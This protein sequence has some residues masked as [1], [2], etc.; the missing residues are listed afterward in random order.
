MKRKVLQLFYSI[1]LLLTTNS[2][3]AQITDLSITQSINNSVPMVGTN[4]VFTI[5]ASNFGPN[6]A[7]VVVVSDVLPTGYAFV[8]A[9]VSSGTTSSGVIWSIGNLASGVTETMTLVATVLP[10]GSYNNCASITGME[11]DPVQTNNSSCI[12]PTPIPVTDLSITKTVND[13]TPNVGDTVYFTLTASNTGPSVATGVLVYDLLPS[14]Y[15]YWSSSVSP[16]DA[17]TGIWSIGTINNGGNAVYTIPAVVNSS[18]V[19]VNCAT[20]SG[21]QADPVNANNS[22]CA[23]VTPL[24]T[25]N[26]GVVKLISNSNPTSGSTVTFTISAINNGPSQASAVAISDLLPTGY[27]FVSAT[28]SIGTYSS[29]SGIWDLGT[30]LTGATPVLTINAIVNASGNYQNCASIYS[31]SYDPYLTNNTSCVSATVT[32]I[33]SPPV[34]NDTSFVTLEDTP[35]VE[36]IIDNDWDIDGTIDSSTVDLS[37]T[38]IG[39]Q[40]SITNTYGTWSVNGSGILT[41]T[42]LANF[43]GAAQLSYTV[44]DNQG[45]ASNVATVYVTVTCV[46]DAPFSFSE[47]IVVPMNTL[48]TGN[49]FAQGDYDLETSLSNISVMVPYVSSG[50]FAISSSLGG[51]YYTPIN[52]FLGAD[53]IQ[54]TFCDDGVPVPMMCVHDTIFINVV[55]LPPA[56]TADLAI[57]TTLDNLNP[58][59]GDTILFSI[60]VNNN[61]PDTATNVLVN[62]QL[63]SGYIYLSSS[64]GSGSYVPS[65]GDWTIGSLPNGALDSLFIAA[66]IDTNGLYQVCSTITGSETDPFLTNNSDCIPPVVISNLGCISGT[67]YCDSNSNSI[68]DSFEVG[69]P[70]VP[71]TISY[72][73]QT[74]TV[75]A[76]SSGNYSFS[77]VLSSTSNPAFVSISSTWLS[78]NGYQYNST[79]QTVL[80]LNC[81]SGS[82]VNF[83]VNCDSSN[84]QQNCVMGYVYCD[85]NGNDTLDLGEIV[86]PN[87]P[88]VVSITGVP[89]TYVYTDSSGFYNF[90]SGSVNFSIANV[91]IPQSWLSI[92]GYSGLA[93]LTGIPSMCDSSIISSLGVNCTPTPCTDMHASIAQYSSYFQNQNNDVMLTWGTWGPTAPQSYQLKVVFPSSVTPVT[94]SFLNQ[95]YTIS[96][97]SIIWNVTSSSSSYFLSNDVIQFF[98]PI[99]DSGNHVYSVTISPTDTISDCNLTNNSSLTNIFVGNSYDPNDKTVDK[100]AQIDPDVQDEFR[101]TIRFQNTGTAPAQNVFIIDTLSANLDWSTINVLYYSHFMQMID[102]GNGVM[103]FNFPG[104]WLPDSNANE[105]ASHGQ[106]V[107]S[108]KENVGNGN[109]ST[110]LNT[111]YIYFDWNPAIITNTT[112]NTNAYLG[113]EDISVNKVKIYPNPFADKITISSA[114]RMD[115]ISVLDITGKVIFKNEVNDFNSNLQLEN[116]SKG[117]YLVRVHTGSEISVVRIVKN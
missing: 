67:I 77:F 76:D 81:L 21:N 30:M 70:N 40:N 23:N 99:G 8:S 117:T 3:N 88:I 17:T 84:I 13:S 5:T 45:A 7:T 61:G 20:I 107:F 109:G 74:Q 114:K 47:Y 89:D 92:N 90:S 113:L 86:I 36:I 101:Y 29:V 12:V 55:P 62:H 25:A 69:V 41:F 93:S 75:V 82:P 108:I 68:L 27:T 64:P 66:Q 72:Y 103:K 10:T 115:K 104:I 58:N 94:S 46:N 9:A 57:L 53:T 28:P 98:V 35:L 95:N 83:P 59:I 73:G 116:L 60:V 79:L 34:A 42:P 52:G 110:I 22:S 2:V 63:P 32:T 71:V 18:G 56:P 26:L 31:A 51:Y 33:N 14:G 15:T 6:A 39:I 4:V 100:L 49:Y 102:L 1:V 24:A 54:L 78:Q 38:V 37:P 65:T 85:A 106:V 91:S 44:K 50:T 80:N 19:Y 112:V 16:Y 105:P 87:A 48:Y 43:C 97:D 111:G 11:S 96:G